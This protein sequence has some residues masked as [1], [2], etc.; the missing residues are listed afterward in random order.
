MQAVFDNGLCNKYEDEWLDGFACYEILKEE[1]K[2]ENEETKWT[3]M[4]SHM[5]ETYFDISCIALF[6]LR[7]LLCIV[8]FFQLVSTNS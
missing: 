6:F 8:D 2:V 3:K 1:W 5:K 4:S 7:F